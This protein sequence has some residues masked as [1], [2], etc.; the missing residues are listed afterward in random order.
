M[1]PL[2]TL[3]QALKIRLKEVLPA[4]KDNSKTTFLISSHDL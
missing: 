4:E 1:K 2:K 3:T